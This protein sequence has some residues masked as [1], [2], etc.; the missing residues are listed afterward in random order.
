MLTVQMARRAASTGQSKTSAT[1]IMAACIGGQY[2]PDHSLLL[3]SQKHGW[4]DSVVGLARR[5]VRRTSNTLLLMGC[6]VLAR[7]L[8]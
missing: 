5:A 7:I 1:L 6:C 8:F 4:D 2:Q 3:A